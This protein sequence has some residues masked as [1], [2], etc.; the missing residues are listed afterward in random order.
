MIVGTVRNE[1]QNNYKE[2]GVSDCPYCDSG[3]CRFD[4]SKR[5]SFIPYFSERLEII[6]KAFPR[7]SKEGKHI[8]SSLNYLNNLYSADD[9]RKLN[10]KLMEKQVSNLEGKVCYE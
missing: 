4:V 8:K 7:K 6:R 1:H 3:D 5:C 9:T 10:V 2:D